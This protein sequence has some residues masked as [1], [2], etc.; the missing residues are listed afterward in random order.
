MVCFNSWQQMDIKEIKDII[1]QGEGLTVE[2]KRTFNR[3]VVETA[4]AFANKEGGKIFIGIAD[5][6]DIIGVK[7][8]CA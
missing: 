3:Q 7:F 4:V 6:G 2:F 8:N 1:A 5:N